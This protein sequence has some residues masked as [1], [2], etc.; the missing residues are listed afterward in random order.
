MQ[1]I[2][3]GTLYVTDKHACFA[4][5]GGGQIKFAIAFKDITE[6]VKVVDRSR[7][8]GETL[9]ACRTSAPVM[10]AWP[11]LEH[12]LRDGHMVVLRPLILPLHSLA[13]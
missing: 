7:K 3:P 13:S 10:P 5:P 6:A 1:V 2:F 8:T 9:C 12:G 11:K 4:A